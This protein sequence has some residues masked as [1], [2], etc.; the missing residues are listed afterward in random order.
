VDLGWDH[1]VA[2]ITLIYDTLRITHHSTLLY[3]CGADS[4]A[5][6][7]DKII[8]GGSIGAFFFSLSTYV[9]MW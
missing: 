3:T 9:E 6:I 2:G 7:N 8:I 4:T 1:V 5:S